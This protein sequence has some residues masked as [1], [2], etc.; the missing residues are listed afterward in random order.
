MR[1]EGISVIAWG[2]WGMDHGISFYRKEHGEPK[3]AQPCDCRPLLNACLKCKKR[4]SQRDCQ[5][6]R[7]GTEPAFMLYT[8][9]QRP[10]VSKRDRRHMPSSCW[11]KSRAIHGQLCIASLFGLD[12]HLQS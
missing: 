9:L 3:D 10:A 6:D 11:T 7:G 2:C 8:C 4:G 5:L 1:L 12:R